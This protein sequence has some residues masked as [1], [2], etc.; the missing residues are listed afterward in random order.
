MQMSFSICQA[1]TGKTLRIFPFVFNLQPC[2]TFSIKFVKKWLQEYK[3]YTNNIY[4]FIDNKTNEVQKYTLRLHIR[5]IVSMASISANMCVTKLNI[6]K[7]IFFGLCRTL[8]TEA[9]NAPITLSNSLDLPDF[10]RTAGKC[11]KFSGRFLWE[12]QAVMP[13]ILEVWWQTWT[14]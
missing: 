4:I 2:T 3:Q 1:T 7:G 5:N 13:L 10:T 14:P 6:P 8:S 11:F 12:A 9:C